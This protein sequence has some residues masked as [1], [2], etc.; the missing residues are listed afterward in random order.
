M[1]KDKPAVPEEQAASSSSQAAVTYQRHHRSRSTYDS[2][3]ARK[4]RQST[5]VMDTTEQ[6]RSRKRA[7]GDTE[8]ANL[9]GL[10][11][12]PEPVVVVKL[13]GAHVG[14]TGGGMSRSR[15]ASARV[16]R[17]AVS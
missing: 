1:L 2:P 7:G 17:G 16:R 3:T 9:T 14:R 10:P 5:E 6:P 12:R 13:T 8:D 11:A 4:T 15:C